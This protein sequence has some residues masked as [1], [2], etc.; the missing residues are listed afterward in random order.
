MTTQARGPERWF[1]CPKCGLLGVTP[2]RHWQLTSHHC[3]WCDLSPRW[4][5]ADELLVLEQQP[6]AAQDCRSGK[7]VNMTKENGHVVFTA[8]GSSAPERSK[9]HRRPGRKGK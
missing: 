6:T 9:A 1:T 7:N 3:Q 2:D 8:W 5:D 4:L